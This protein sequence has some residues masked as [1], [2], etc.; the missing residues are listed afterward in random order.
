MK[1][2]IS[3]VVHLILVCS[4]I[5]F[6]PVAIAQTNEKPRIKKEIKKQFDL[7]NNTK[8]LETQIETEF[9]IYGKIIQ[10]TEFDVLPEG[11]TALNKQTI[12]KYNINGQLIGSMI[13][14][15][16]NSLLSREDISLD[17]ENRVTKVVKIDYTK[18][19]HQFLTTSYDYDIYGNEFLV[20]T[21]D[22]KNNLTSERRKIFNHLGDMTMQDYWYFVEDKNKNKVKYII[23]TENQFDDTGEITKSTSDIQKGKKKW[24]EVRYFQNSAIVEYDK[25]ENGKLVSHY[26]ITERDTSYNNPAYDVLPI[27]GKPFPMEYDDKERDVLQGIDHTEFLSIS[28][29][30]DKNGNIDKKVLREK[31]EV[32][33]VTHYTYSADNLLLKEVTID[34]ASDNEEI[35]HYEYD[36]Y[37]NLIRKTKYF[38]NI[39]L[40]ELSFAYEYYH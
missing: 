17:E 4:Y 11:R 33:S 13:Y 12:N 40:Q 7:K 26:K 39:P 18:T 37:R 30:T 19:P 38:N 29:K 28:M 1:K 5:L 21:F 27:P 2:T 32:I 10:L 3:L 23:H 22:T 20:R 25:Y 36:Q 24:K 6:Y 15:L 34:K 8:I 31:G 14:D 16:N 35:T 9:D